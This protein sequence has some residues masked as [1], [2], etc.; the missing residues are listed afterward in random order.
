MSE[1]RTLIKIKFPPYKQSFHS[2][3]T[4]AL[5]K[6]GY[7]I[8]SIF[9]ISETGLGGWFQEDMP[10]IRKAAMLMLHLRDSLWFFRKHPLCKSV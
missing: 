10:H 9:I 7:K 4:F 3:G 2:L 5:R 8:A 6:T 1:R